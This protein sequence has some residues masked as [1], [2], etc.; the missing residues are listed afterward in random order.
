MTLFFLSLRMLERGVSQL[1]P[2]A[3]GCPHLQP[4]LGFSSGQPLPRLTS[5]VVRSCEVVAG[6]VQSLSR[7]QLFE[8]PWTLAHQV[9]LS[10]A[11]IL[12]WVVISFSMG[13]SWIRD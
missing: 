5:L 9:P 8:I 3:A 12:E 6:V 2:E 13:S 4:T 10:T 7:V 1:G 11:R